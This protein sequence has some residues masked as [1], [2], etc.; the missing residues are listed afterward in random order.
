MKRVLLL[1][2]PGHEKYFRDNY[3]S[4][5]SKA[6]YY[7]QPTDLLVQSGH[8]APFYDLDIVDAIVEN[9]SVDY[10]LDLVKK[11]EYYA[12]L[13]L[14]G[15]ASWDQDLQLLFLILSDRRNKRSSKEAK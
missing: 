11:S 10:I 1:N 13:A 3:C 15:T 8:L 9:L 6:G 12:I 5:I 4:P 2:P 14:S 7:W